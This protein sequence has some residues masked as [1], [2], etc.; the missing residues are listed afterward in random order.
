MAT[1][2]IKICAVNFL[3]KF[4][5]EIVD[6]GN[7]AIVAFNQRPIEQKMAVTVGRLV[8]DSEKMLAKWREKGIHGAI[9]PLPVFLMGF[10]KGYNS[11]GLEKG[12]SVPMRN[13]VFNDDLGN[14]FKVRMSKHDQRVQIVLYAPDHETAFLLADQFKLYCA[15]YENR[16]Q[17]AYTEYNGRSY[18]FPMTLEDNNLFGANQ[19]IAEQDNLT[20][21]VFDL[22]FTCHTPYF[23]GDLINHQ[24]YLPVVRAVVI[25][26]NHYQT[27]ENLYHKVVRDP[28]F[29]FEVNS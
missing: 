10:D 4:F 9:S 8:D 2:A 5:E 12:R 27:Q 17:Y 22:T 20:V 23:E 21:L 1:K 19:Q 18:P 11:S 26:H 24:P 6:N 7:K 25:D 15:R 13:V 29:L 14:F 28:M 3:K 16:H